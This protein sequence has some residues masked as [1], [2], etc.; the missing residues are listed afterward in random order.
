MKKID[1]INQKFGKLTV[2]SEH[3]KSRSNHIR[4]S[5]ICDCGNTIT[6]LG[7][8]LREG[9]AK[10]CGCSHKKTGRDNKRW[11]G[12]ED[13]SLTYFNN[14]RISATSG[15]RKI[16]EFEITLEYLWNLFLIQNKKCALS[17]IELKFGRGIHDKSNTASLDRIDSSKGYIESNVQW[18]HKDINIMKNKLKDDYF[19]KMC[20][21]V[22]SNN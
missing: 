11:Q 8:H 18:V 9:N 13:I 5:C 2:L 7:A 16:M 10:S 22:A 4:Y 12:Y 19:I 20:K 1:I 6:T 14:L 21:N 17:G 15:R 3:S